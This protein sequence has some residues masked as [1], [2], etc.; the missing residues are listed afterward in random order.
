MDGQ[1]GERLG[2]LAGGGSLPSVVARG[3]LKKGYQPLFARFG[4]GTGISRDTTFEG[5]DF[6]WGEAGNAIVWLRKMQV[7]RVVFCGTISRRPDFRALVPS[8]QT[9]KRLPAALSIVRG[10]DDRLLRNLARYLERQGFTLLPVQAVAPE[11]LTP[12]GTL[13][14]RVPD[15]QEWSALESARR[16][17]FALGHLDAGQAVVASN[18]RIVALEGIEGTREM[19]RRVADLQKRGRIHGSERLVLVKAVKPDQDH[20]FDLPS[21]GMRTIDEAVEAGISAVGLSA[22]AS[23]ILDYDDVIAAANRAM[24]ALVGLSTAGGT[25]LATGEAR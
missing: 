20:R 5:R 4:D 17:A 14:R 13:T 15:A 12:E 7:R 24:I 10:G 11:L 2:I 19:M 9:L 3:A 6:A 21:I 1:S 22:G 25:D 8:W 16:A 23:L 18:E